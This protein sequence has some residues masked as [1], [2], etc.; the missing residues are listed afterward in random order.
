MAARWTYS[1]NI[2]DKMFVLSS[3][4][5]LRSDTH[6]QELFHEEAQQ[7]SQTQT[8]PWWKIQ[9]FVWEPVLFGT[10]DGVFTSC[11][12]NI[13]GVVLFLR[14]G[15]LVGNT[16]ILMGMFLVSFVVV[17][18]LVTVLS[19]IG[20]CERCSIGSGGVYSM[21]STVL[22]GQVGGTI[23]LFYIFGQ[24]VAGA[25]YIT[26]FAESISDLLGFS[27]TWAVR[28]I[29]LA[30]LL[31]LLGINLAGVKWIIRL[32]LLLLFLLAVSTLDFVIGSF[33]HLDP[34]HGFVGYSKELMFNNTLPDY[35]TGESFFTVFGV[36]FPAATGVMAGF[37][38]SGDLQKPEASIPLGSLAAIGIS[39]FLYIVFV[40]LLGA[41][42]TRESLRYDFLI[43]EKKGRNKT[44][45]AAICLT[46]LI[47][48][49]FVFIGQ[50]NILAPIVTINF[51]LTY[52]AVDYS[53]FSVS[54]SY[55]LQQKPKRTQR[56]ESRVVNSAQPL[57]FAKTS[58]YG[59][60]GIIQ[61]RSDGTL[62]EFTKDMDQL[63]KPLNKDLGTR[64]E[65]EERDKNL[66]QKVKQRKIK[67]PAK[68]TLQDSFLLDLDHNIAPA[69]YCCT[70][71]SEPSD[72][73]LQ[74]FAEQ[75][76]Q[77]ERNLCLSSAVDTEQKRDH[78]L[79][80]YGEQ[81][82]NELQNPPN[83]KV[84][85][86]N[87]KQQNQELEIQRMPVSFY[88]RFCNH[89]VS[90]VGAI[91]SL[92]IMFVIQ[93]IYTLINLSV[94]IIL[95]FYIGQM[96]PGLPPGEGHTQ[97]SRL[98]L[99]R[100]LQQLAWRP[101]SSPKRMQIL[102]LETAATILLLS[103]EKNLSISFSKKQKQKQNR[104][105]TPAVA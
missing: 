43:A 69:P 96:S 59:S 68:Q 85:D 44:P 26:G 29:S 79:V 6:V 77:S 45:V 100:P 71:T 86:T 53:Y 63:F 47:T 13:F 35:S 5:G 11:M 41:I 50:V 76:H 3:A 52:I 34:E 30:V 94:A 21:I 23:G 9:L 92:V 28:G 24:C 1:S 42:C 101:L 31:G 40:F 103:E 84:E 102:P 74:S 65:K 70:K 88:A 105:F 15:W 2:K 58:R 10:W 73:S 12:I 38:M 20:V 98:L 4:A 81:L 16:G 37:N 61:S 51:M 60:D 18:A 32:Q 83:Q 22:G 89:W 97:R 75:S 49:A 66:N 8:K 36:F 67:K 95:Y 90:L 27:S 19:G 99:H 91:G 33:T 82:F 46:S 78:E 80:E 87:V 25:M 72:E 56:E 57:T 104:L 7:V 39:W 54:M 48:M 64:K 93:W 17:V 62:L 55:I 14:T